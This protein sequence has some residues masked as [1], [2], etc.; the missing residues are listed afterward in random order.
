MVCS[1]S[2]RRFGMGSDACLTLVLMWVIDCVLVSVIAYSPFAAA[3][4]SIRHFIPKQPIKYIQHDIRRRDEFLRLYFYIINKS[5]SLWLCLLPNAWTKDSRAPHKFDLV[6]HLRFDQ[7]HRISHDHWLIWMIAASPELELTM[8]FA[9]L[10]LWTGS[11]LAIKRWY[12][13]SAVW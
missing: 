1:L 12:W 13:P 6:A 4:S 7:P 5:N 11:E 2:S 9:P 3:L 8:L 10:N